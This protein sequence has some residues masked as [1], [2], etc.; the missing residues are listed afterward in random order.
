MVQVITLASLLFTRGAAR[1]ADSAELLD[2]L[3][4][5]DAACPEQRDNLSD[6]LLDAALASVLMS[7]MGAEAKLNELYMEHS[8]SPEVSHWFPGLEP[9]LAARFEAA[10]NAGAMKLSPIEKVDLALVIAGVPPLDWA[11]PIPQRFRLLHTLRNDLV[12]HKPLSVRH[13]Q[14]SADSDDKLER[15]LHTQF[16]SARIWTGKGAAYRWNG[17]LGAGCARWATVTTHA[18]FALFF[19]RL[20]IDYL[21]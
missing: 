20:G 10:W 6:S 9:Q 3:S 18:F 19:G 7:Y 8:L 16:D 12:H 13:G 2:D 5:F 1:F 11:T 14:V 17:C 21:K 4:I 15:K